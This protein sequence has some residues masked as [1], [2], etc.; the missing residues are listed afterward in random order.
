MRTLSDKKVK[1]RKQHQCFGCLRIFPA[2]SEMRRQV[3]TGD[4]GLYSVYSCP[5]CDGLM[6]YFD[7]YGDGFP[8]GFS[9]EMKQ[10]DGFSG[11]FEDYLSHLQESAETIA[12]LE[13]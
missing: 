4:D 8:E 3:N 7:D 11:T 1:T 2:K 6:A 5:A 9:R 13:K 10:E 12:C